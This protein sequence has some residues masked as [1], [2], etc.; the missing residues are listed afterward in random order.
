MVLKIRVQSQ[1][2]SY[3]RLKNLRNGVAPFPTPQCSSYW[4]GSRW[5]ASTKVTNFTYNVNTI[6]IKKEYNMYNVNELLM[7]LF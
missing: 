6:K 2:E 3:Q 4:K 5:V 1:V 7:I